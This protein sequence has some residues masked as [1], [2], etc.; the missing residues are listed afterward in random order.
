MNFNKFVYRERSLH[1]TQLYISNI[2]TNNFITENIRDKTVI[3]YKI[4]LDKKEKVYRGKTK[5]SIIAACL[6]KAFDLNM[7]INNLIKV[8]NYFNIQYNDTA[9]GLTILVEVLNK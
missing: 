3:L 8:A 7:T 5:I 2:C 1:D 9:K 6:F 4:F